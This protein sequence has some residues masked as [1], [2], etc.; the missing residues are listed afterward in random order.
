MA[1]WV[2]KMK[3]TMQPHVA[4]PVVA[5]GILQPAGSWGAFGAGMLSPLAGSIL[6]RKADKKAGGLAD[7]GDHFNP[8]KNVKMAMF[9]LT[10]DKLYAFSGKPGART[11]RSVTSS[12]RGSATT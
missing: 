8:F 2:Q 7:S 6:R 3:D 12:A 9:A 4:E 5:V 10:A 11:G 1:D